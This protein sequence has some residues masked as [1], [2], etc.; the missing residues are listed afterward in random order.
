M[1]EAGG[2][3]ELKCPEQAKLVGAMYRANPLRNLGAII[4]G[5]PG[6][7]LTSTQPRLLTINVLIQRDV[8]AVMVCQSSS[9]G[10]GI[11][12][13]ALRCSIRRTKKGGS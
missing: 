2:E 8:N 4:G 11:N 9:R 7:S 13:V 5:R 1:S 12:D 6:S 10:G 3:V